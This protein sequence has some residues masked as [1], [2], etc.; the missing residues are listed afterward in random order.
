MYEISNRLETRRRKIHG[1]N[2]TF[3]ISVVNF[4]TA[5][6]LYCLQNVKSESK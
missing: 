1:R 2:C 3:D 5:C 6:K 4:A